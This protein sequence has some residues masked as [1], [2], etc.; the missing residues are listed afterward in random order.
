MRH[1]GRYR[2]AV[3]IAGVLISATPGTVIAQRWSAGL[4]A[5]YVAVGGTQF[6][7]LGD[8]LGVD[9]FVRYRDGRFGIEV[10]SRLSRHR[11]WLLCFSADCTPYVHRGLSEV[12]VRPAL[13]P[14]LPSL[15]FQP[16]LAGHLGVTFG[17]F[18]DE[19]PGVGLGGVVGVTWPIH[20]RIAL[21]AGLAGSAVYVG[22]GWPR[23]AWGRQL[24][25]RTG[26]VIR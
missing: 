4:G 10:G 26:L 9:G 14:L 6:T 2:A 15:P 5:E 11:L 21:D 18:Q 24:A 17:E 23:S 7:N 25:F 8:G 20:S 3:I 1:H 22:T 16:Y 12:Y 19:S 13:L